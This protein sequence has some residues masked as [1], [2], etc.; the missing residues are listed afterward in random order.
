M[1]SQ[2]TFLSDLQIKNWIDWCGL[3]ADYLDPLKVEKYE[4]VREDDLFWEK[5][6]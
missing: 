2:K 4:L 3:Y 6:W 5:S 1:K